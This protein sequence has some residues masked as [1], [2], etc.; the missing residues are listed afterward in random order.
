M[1]ITASFSMITLWVNI[2]KNYENL[3]A[4]QVVNLVL[5]SLCAVGSAFQ[6]LITHQRKRFQGCLTKEFR[7]LANQQPY[8]SEPTL[9]PGCLA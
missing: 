5:Q 4:E 8:K 1:L 9:S 6:S 3:Y 2:L 7:P